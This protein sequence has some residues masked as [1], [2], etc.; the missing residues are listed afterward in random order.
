MKNSAKNSDSSRSSVSPPVSGGPMLPAKTPGA[1]SS[2]SLSG[3]SAEWLEAKIESIGPLIFGAQNYVDQAGRAVKE[4]IDKA[5]D[6]LERLMVRYPN[7][8]RRTWEVLYDIGTGRVLPELAMDASY[9]AQMARRLPVGEQRKLLAEGVMVA[10]AD[11]TV[12]KP[13]KELSTYECQRVFRPDGKG[14]RTP[15]EQFA[16][17]EAIAAPEPTYEIDPET[18]VITFGHGAHFMPDQLIAIAE[19]AKAESIK[20]LPDYIRRSS[21]A[22]KA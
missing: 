22:A 8:S 18:G 12:V 1:G 15:E 19:R 20:R 21:G 2:T 6:G 13:L 10:K 5:A 7:V 11:G 17:R 14:I 3:P 4:V 16:H 9:G